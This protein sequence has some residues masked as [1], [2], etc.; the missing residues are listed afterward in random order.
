[1]GAGD[2][3]RGVLEIITACNR[4]GARFSVVGLLDDCPGK[5]AQPVDGMPVLGGLEWLGTNHSDELQYVVAVADCAVKQRL[6]M[7]LSP[8]AP[9]YA[10]LVHPSAILSTGVVVGPGAI[11]GAGVVIARNTLVGDHVTINLNSTVGHDCVI[12]PFTTVAPGANVAGRVHV[13]E[14]CAIGLNATLVRGIRIQDWSF[15]GP[16]AV[17]LRDVYTGQRVFGNP[18]RVVPGRRGAS[19]GSAI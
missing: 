2:H 7:R 16:G 5:R 4:A 18:A 1:M 3:G 10:T 14:G 17:V 9:R 6:A 8:F 15:V 11:I 19:T 12:G 13:G